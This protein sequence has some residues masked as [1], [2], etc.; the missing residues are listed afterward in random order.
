MFINT[1]GGYSGT[2]K[3]IGTVMAI[4]D[5]L[6]AFATVAANHSYVRPE[7]LPSESGVLSLKRLRH[8]CLEVQEGV[9]YVPNDVEMK[10]GKY[11][12]NLNVYQN[13]T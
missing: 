1:T 4:L 11:A 9:N 8:P 5:V 3:S 2:I 12:F 6:T 10:R 7:L 13:N